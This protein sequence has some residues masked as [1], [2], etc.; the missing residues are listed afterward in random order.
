MIINGAAQTAQ[1]LATSRGSPS[2]GTFRNKHYSKIL[3][4][5]ESF[6]FDH[7]RWIIEARTK[8]EANK[9]ILNSRRHH[10]CYKFGSV[11]Q[12]IRKGK[13][14]GCIL[15]R[16]GIGTLEYGKKKLALS[17][18]N[19]TKSL[20]AAL[21]MCRTWSAWSTSH[22]ESAEIQSEFWLGGGRIFHIQS[23]NLNIHTRKWI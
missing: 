3:Y 16:A 23:Y 11:I 19:T 18:R 22:V 14:T 2:G 5:R 9:V 1:V 20:G 7:H 8:I 21:L 17:P 4:M 15:R 13:K 12:F 10:H 6:V